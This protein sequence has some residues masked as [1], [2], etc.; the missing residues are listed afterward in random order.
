MQTKLSNYQLKDWYIETAQSRIQ[1]SQ[2][3]RREKY[4]K[5]LKLPHLP[6]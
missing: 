6:C 3:E 2:G 1:E 5:E 4:E